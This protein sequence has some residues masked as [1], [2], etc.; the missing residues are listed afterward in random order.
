MQICFSS[1]QQCRVAGAA[2]RVGETKPAEQPARLK[3]VGDR[4][5]ISSVP[6][7]ELKSTETAKNGDRIFSDYEDAE[8]NHNKKI[9][10]KRWRSVSE[11]RLWCSELCLLLGLGFFHNSKKISLCM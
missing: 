9:K 1:A 5:C 11:S 6:F 8:F 7:S 3:K 2:H 10:K 4:D